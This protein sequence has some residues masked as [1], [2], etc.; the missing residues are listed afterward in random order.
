MEAKKDFYLPTKDSNLILKILGTTYSVVMSGIFAII[1]IAYLRG[2]APLNAVLAQLFLIIF[3][4]SLSHFS[5]KANRQTGLYIELGRSLVNVSIAG[6]LVFYFMEGTS[7]APFWYVYLLVAVGQVS[8]GFEISKAK[9]MGLGL[10]T[11]TA[12]SYI[13]C[14]V[15]VGHHFNWYNVA[16]HVLT[17]MAFGVLFDRILSLTQNSIRELLNKSNELKQTLGDLQAANQTIMQQSKLSAIGEMAGGIAHEINNPLTIIASTARLMKKAHTTDN[18]TPDMLEKSLA[19]I[20]ETVGRMTKIITGMKNISKGSRGEEF[21]N[22]NLKVVIE[23]V[24][25]LSNTKFKGTGLDIQLDMEDFNFT[26]YGD[27]VQISQV[28]LNLFNNAYD[29]I[30]EKEIKWIKLTVEQTPK[31]YCIY[32]ADSGDGISEEVRS[33][34]FLPFFTTKKIGKGTGMG[35]GISKSIMSNHGGDLELLPDLEKT[36]FL[37]TLPRPA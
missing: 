8:F 36:C 28:F 18:L 31:A 9:H 37:V 24:I 15:L 10:C 34:I 14:V 3:N 16:T 23:D 2:D 29:A 35:L 5:L 12:A 25:S 20:E 7:L 4:L 6:P 33:R 26:V 19:R 21:Q 27:Q 11:L 22:F 13:I 17:M 30:E 32:F 1:L